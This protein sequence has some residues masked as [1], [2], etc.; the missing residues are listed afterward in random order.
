MPHGRSLPLAL[1]ILLAAAAP[2]ASDWTRF[3][4]PN[5]TG[6]AD[7]KDIP[8]EFTNKTILWKVELPP[9]HSSPVVYKDH[10]YVEA[11]SKDAKER[12]LLCLSTK[13]GEVLWKKTV[14]AKPAAPKGK[15][16]LIHAMNSYS[17]ASPGVDAER[18]YAVF[19]DNANLLLHAYSH[20]GEQLWTK[21]LGPFS[22]EH[23]PGNSPIPMGDKVIFA[24]EQDG[25]SVLLVLEGKSGNVVWSDERPAYRACYSAPMLRDMPAGQG[26]EL[27]VVSTM[28]ITG[29]DFDS[30]SKHWNYEPKFAA[31]SPLRTAS[32]PVLVG[33]LLIAGG[34]DGGGPRH[35]F[36][37]R[38]ADGKATLAW[39]NKKDFP[40]VPSIL[41]RGKYLYFVNDKGSAGCFEVETG[42]KVWLERLEGEFTSSPILIDGKI[43]A[44]NHDGDVFVIAAEP[45]FQ[46]LAKNSLGELVRATPA[47]ADGRLYIRGERHL[48]CIGKA[49]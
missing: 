9:G 27:L 2:A 11:N 21:D 8:V 20:S 3:R 47:V 42:N 14:A 5:G 48:F 30:G 36:A 19:W 1:A 46:L 23:G 22:S 39:E 26:K 29:Y 35:T 45:K 15:K 10:I 40:Y 31:K 13:D 49:K 38:I 6:V 34:G 16:G 37:V 24:N 7:D 25:K 41:A 12:M 33:N 28:A 18:V 4:G 17:S 32:S 43:Y 44:A